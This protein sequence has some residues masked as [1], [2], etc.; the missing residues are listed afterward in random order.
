MALSPDQQELRKHDEVVSALGNKGGFVEQNLNILTPIDRIWQPS[1]MLPD[2]TKPDWFEQ[3]TTLQNM[4]AGLPDGILVV[5]VGNAVTEEGIPA[6][7]TWLNRVEPISDKTGADDTPWA[8]WV[9]GWT[10][11]EKRHDNVLDN[12]MRLCGRVDMHAVDRT[13][14]SLIAYGF[15]S[16]VGRDP[17]RAFTYTA[18]Q[19]L[20]TKISHDREGDMAE[21]RGDKILARICRRIAGDESRHY[22]FYRNAMGEIINQDTEGAILAFRDMMRA[23]VAMP[24]ALMADG[25]VDDG[26]D[27][28]E[29]SGRKEPTLFEKYAAVAQSEGVYTAADYIGIT[30]DLMR[31][32]RVLDRSVST[33]EAKRAQDELGRKFMRPRS[34]DVATRVMERSRMKADPHFR[35]IYNRSVLLKRAA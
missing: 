19:E 25:K 9:R 23:E 35:W 7:M 5:L 13:I 17:Y 29:S 3:V 11:E 4:A 31:H 24:G 33:D 15:D 27:E 30:R 1:D 21:A 34:I 10:S 32:W 22:T 14:Q 8:R 12:W 20:A 16:G 18:F 28:A 26:S 6:Y 2:F